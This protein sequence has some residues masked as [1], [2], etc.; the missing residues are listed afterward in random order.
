MRK[1]RWLAGA[2][3]L[4]GVLIA[5]LYGWRLYRASQRVPEFYQQALQVEPEAHAQAGRELEKEVQILQSEAQKHGA[6]QAVFTDDQINGWLVSE[7]PQRFPRALPRDV[8]EPRVSIQEDLAWIG[9]RYE[10]SGL[11]AVISIGLDV[12]LT[13]EPNVL[14]VR[15]RN[16]MAG[17]APLPV[18][19][20]LDQITAAAARSQIAVRWTEDA[21]E[22][23]A[24]VTVPSTYEE[25]ANKRVYLESVDLTMG[26]LRLAGHTVDAGASDE[27]PHAPQR[28]L[29]AVESPAPQV[30][31]QLSTE[32]PLTRQTSP[33]LVFPSV[34]QPAAQPHFFTSASAGSLSG[35]AALLVADQLQLVDQFAFPDRWS[36]GRSW[37]GLNLTVH[38]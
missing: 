19:P 27:P 3:L 17:D 29:G 37:S 1:T 18:K 32:L 15:V 8:R 11:S 6:W 31:L 14:A 25:F 10:T 22:P 12:Q 33:G 34:E 2:I 5:G 20:W 30:A 7:M 23:V 21:G 36:S 28:L 35:P 26:A 24:L 38:R 13:E 16:A 4:S 9:C